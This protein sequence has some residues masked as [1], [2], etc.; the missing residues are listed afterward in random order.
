[1]VV[2]Y[3]DWAMCGAQECGERR[4]GSVTVW[5]QLRLWQGLRGVLDFPYFIFPF[6][7]LILINFIPCYRDNLRVPLQF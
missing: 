5:S 4:H 7:F 6:S 3:S 2:S 1:M